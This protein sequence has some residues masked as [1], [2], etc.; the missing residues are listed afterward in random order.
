MQGLVNFNEAVSLYG[1]PEGYGTV[2]VN[3]IGNFNVHGNNIYVYVEAK[4]AFPGVSYSALLDIYQNDNLFCSI[5]IS[6]N[7]LPRDMV[8]ATGH[9]PIGQCE[10]VLPKTGSV[11]IKITMSALYED[12]SGRLA[13]NAFYSKIISK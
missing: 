6:S 11:R 10:A 5:P 7:G 3:F 13:R 2:I 8:Y 12:G 4:A 1:G 9:V